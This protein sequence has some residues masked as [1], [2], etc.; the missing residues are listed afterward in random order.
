G[1][2]KLPRGKRIILFSPHPDDDVISAGGIL[3]KLHQNG[4]DIIVA[5][6]TSGSIAVFDH[7]VRRHLDFLR[8]VA[9]E[10]DLDH[11]RV[12][13]LIGEIE[14]FFARKEPG[15]VD[16]PVVQAIKRRIRETEAIAGIQTFG[17]RAEQARFLN[18]PF[19]QTG[20]VRKDPIGEEDIRDRKSTR[21]NSSH[22]KISYA[23]FCLKK[24]NTIGE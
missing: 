17:M 22:V 12:D 15:E 21:L 5:Y 8:R 2:S 20:K 24:K 7:D 13:A 4:N 3:N 9:D 14:E 23:V 16:I 19:Y 18:L 10:F 11:E 1:R 6:Q